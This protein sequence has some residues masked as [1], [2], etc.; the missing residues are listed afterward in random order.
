MALI[1]YWV[2]FLL[3]G[4]VLRAD[5]GRF[6]QVLEEGRK[7]WAFRE[8]KVQ[9]LPLV[10]DKEWPVRR[11]DW[12]VL[13]K[14]EEQKLRPSG[15][16]DGRTLLRR[17][18]FDLTGL[19]PTAA[20]IAEFEADPSAEAYERW[21]ER[22]LASPQY[23]ERW[24][25][26][27]LD[28]ARYADAIA[29]FEKTRGSP[30]LYRDWVVKAFQ[31]DMPYDQFIKRQLATDMMPETGPADAP[32]LGFLG[33]SPSYWKEL[34]LD[35]SLIEMVVAEEWEERIDVIGRTFLGLT[36]A[37][38]RCHDHK[39]DPISQEDYYA[40]AGVLAS[41]RMADRPLVPESEFEPVRQAHQ[42][43]SELQEKLNDLKGKKSTDELKAQIGQLE[44]ELAMLKKKTPGYDQLL[45]NGVAEAALYVEAQGTNRTRLD[46][47]PNEARNL[48]VHLRGNPS[49]LGREIPRG[50]LEVLSATGGR[51]EF[52][53]GSGRLE[54]AESIV[55]EGAPLS[56]RVMVNRVWEHH[57][58]RGLVDT[59]SNFGVR[60]SRP[61]HPELLDDMT[62]RFM[63]N[64]WSIKWLH[65]EMMLSAAYQ[66]GSGYRE[67]A[68]GLDPENRLLWRMN[69]RRLEIEAWRDSLL[70]VSGDLDLRQGGPAASLTEATNYRRTIYGR[71]DRLAMNPMLRLYDFPDPSIHA[72][73]RVP[74]TT[75]IQQLFLLNSDFIQQQAGSLLK[76]LKNESGPDLVDRVDRAHEW[77]LGRPPRE[78]EV[79]WAREFFQGGGTG[80]GA[81]GQVERQWE[82]YL[83]ALL[84]SNEL[85]FVD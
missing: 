31:E 79:A 33:L 43:A 24:A 30:W 11:V 36:L 34:M 76:R 26:F 67:G 48:R 40:V 32:A 27:W 73:Q 66:Q 9:E 37:C 78:E 12:F 1:R 61:S 8:P 54:L 69:R 85:L 38:A 15:R 7:H 41:I 60:G 65:R 3:V 13:S 5:E 25:R 50:F 71:V 68:A 55:R 10:R 58:G 22:L 49:S 63:E 84:G 4:Q 64:G 19:P 21:I 20:E 82:L 16:A 74:T 42:K 70:A 80:A 29:N 83:H 77:L 18:S 59:P 47:R 23:G 81:D 53:K 14:L 52:R 2:V 56:A 45:A 51:K 46:Y 72:E 17:A 75:P 62:A 44:E 57:F 39:Y 35:K 6:E 28:Q